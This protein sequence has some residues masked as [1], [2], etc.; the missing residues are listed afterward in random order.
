MQLSTI[1]TI[2]LAILLL[3]ILSTACSKKVT[4]PVTEE[5]EPIVNQV[6]KV[7]Q[8]G[9]EL[10]KQDFSLDYNQ[11]KTV[12]C[13]SKTI[14]KRPNDIFS[15]L[16]FALYQ[17]DI[18]EVLFRETIP[19]ATGKWLNNREFQV[20]TIPGRMSGRVANATKNGWLFNVQTKTKRKIGK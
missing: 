11:E 13:I 10:F 14:K 8:L 4:P 6:D 19:K 2:L 15:T 9:K 20:T 7:A 18:D 5:Q 16:S 3:I 1:S 12:V 17:I